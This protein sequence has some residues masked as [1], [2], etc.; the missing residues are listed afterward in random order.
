MAIKKEQKSEKL[1]EKYKY[2][3]EGKMM[4]DISTSEP[5]NKNNKSTKNKKDEK[6]EKK[7]EKMVETPNQK[8]PSKK[9]IYTSMLKE[10]KPFI[11]KINGSI[12]FDSE[13]SDIMLLCFEENYFRIGVE[14]H[15]YDGLNFKFKK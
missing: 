10:N 12:V 3:G 7:V 14:K 13:V 1:T 15:T 5:L 2:K 4:S 8:L 9:E 11:L 6:V